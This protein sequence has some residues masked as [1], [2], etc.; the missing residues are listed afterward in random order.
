MALFTSIFSPN[1]RQ[2]NNCKILNP[3]D[4]KAAISAGSVQLVD[5]RTVMEFRSGH[6]AGALNIDYFEQENFR[7]AFEKLDKNK[8]LYIYCRSGNRS[9]KAANRLTDMGFTEIYDLAGGY[10][11]WH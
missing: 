6:I 2:T 3:Q 8:P 10:V 5:V 7:A 11:N 9:Q 4:F 1:V